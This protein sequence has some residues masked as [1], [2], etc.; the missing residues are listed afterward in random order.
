MS[1]RRGSMARYLQTVAE[2]SRTRTITPFAEAVAAP[3][4]PGVTPSM[5]P[6]LGV[7]PPPQSARDMAVRIIEQVLVGPSR[8]SRYYG[9]IPEPE[10]KLGTAAI[11]AGAFS[12]AMQYTAGVTPALDLERFVV[13]QAY[14]KAYTFCIC[15]FYESRAQPPPSCRFRRRRSGSGAFVGRGDSCRFGLGLGLLWHSFGCT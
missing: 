3:L 13:V 5:L 12:T 14:C 7:W 15:E 1:E 8:F 2:E 6:S 10:A 4:P 9:P 11:E